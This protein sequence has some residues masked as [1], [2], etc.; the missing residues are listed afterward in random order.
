MNPMKRAALVQGVLVYLMTMG[1]MLFWARR[2]YSR[3]TWV[4][5]IGWLVTIVFLTYVVLTDHAETP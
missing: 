2:V 1:S 3:P 5:I 4:E